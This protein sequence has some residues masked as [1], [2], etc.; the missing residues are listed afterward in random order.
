M[1]TNTHIGIWM[2]HS[3]AHLTELAGDKVMSRTIENEFSHSDKQLA[4]GRSEHLMHNKEQ[5]EQIAFYKKIAD[6]IKPFDAAVVFG[7][8][9]AKHELLNRLKAQSGFGTKKIEAIHADKMTIKEQQA[10]V[11]D[12][13]RKKAAA[14]NHF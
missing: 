11:R 6:A 9:T 14:M 1:K 4:G 12:Y 7:P 3:I 5:Q 10:F 13:F 8:T 2:D